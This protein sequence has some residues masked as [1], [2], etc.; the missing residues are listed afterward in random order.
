MNNALGLG[1][2]FDAKDLATGVMDRVSA[3]FIEVE[4]ASSRT[5]K[6]IQQNMRQFGLGLT[7]FGSGGAA[8]A[9]AT[10]L[11]NVSGLFSKELAAAGAVAGATAEE[12]RMFESAAL[13]AGMATS[14]DPTQAAR[15]LG[16]I[17][18]AGYS[19][20][21][22]VSTLIPVLQLAEGSLGKL[23]PSGAA[24]LATQTM[25]AFGIEAASAGPMVDKLLKSVN[26]FA[27][28]ADELPLAIGTAARGAGVMRQGLDETLVALGLVKN[29]I[30]RVETASTAVAVAMERMVNP[31]VAA[32]L[33]AQGVAVADAQGNFRPFLDVV[34]DLGGALE[35]MGTEQKRSGFL[36]ETFGTEALG[37][38]NA[39]MA[40]LTNGI[41]T[42][43]G[44]FVKGADAVAYLRD[45]FENST[46]AAKEFSDA[47]LDTFEGQKKLTSGSI[48][49]L[50]VLVGQPFERAL[51]PA[52]SGFLAVLN[53][54]IGAFRAMPESAKDFLA[55]AV[56][57]AGV[58]V[59]VLGGVLAAKAAFG[60]LAAGLSAAGVTAGGFVAAI[61]PAVGI[62]GVAAL[63]VYGLKAAV[64]ANIGGIGD[65]F[66]AAFAKARLA[67]DA[68]TQLFSQ[69]GFSGEVL[70]ELDKAENMGVENFVTRIWL[71]VNRVQEFFRAL[72]EAFDGAVT[73][74]GPVID[75][76]VSAFEELGRALGFMQETIDPSDAGAT[77]D[78]FGRAGAL[79][80]EV[81]GTAFAVVVE[82]LTAIVRV[83]TGVI[84]WIKYLG[85]VLAPVIDQLAPFGASLMMLFGVF[86]ATSSG[87][88]IE[89]VSNVLQVF[90]NVLQ[91]VGN[92]LLWA[93]EVAVPPLKFAID[94][95]SNAVRVVS[96]LLGGLIDFLA[97]VFT[98][99][100][101]RAF[102]GIAK[103]VGGVVHGIIVLVAGLV[104]ALL[105]LV[106]TVAAVFGRSLDTAGVVRGF[107]DDVGKN[108]ETTFAGRPP[109]APEAVVDR[110]IAAA[111][112][113][114]APEPIAPVSS[115]ALASQASTAAATSELTQAA[116]QLRSAKEGQTLVNATMVVDSEVLGRISSQAQR[117]STARGF[118]M[119]SVEEQ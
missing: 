54:I 85:G 88:W 45:G 17:A 53:G 19:A 62:L 9:G 109:A 41:R 34:Q 70:A 26:L 101:E 3:K 30:P 100:F 93:A 52:V 15:S 108:F 81:L 4:G 23:D 105:G 38:L 74:A 115:A 63:A 84:E 103:I 77:F 44:E 89:A 59:T 102:M 119:V 111:Q 94:M 16:D 21:D 51:K 98:L 64:D 71:T 96:L 43:S 118:G 116:T 99:N 36:V 46:G 42:S 39:I 60:I 110:D 55:R 56:L 47:L 112:A 95:V 86:G 57:V 117:S 7:L 113:F 58:L 5:A 83:G 1:F 12:L 104:E 31:E 66:T 72:G 29:I 13:D 49:T 35:K 68:L 18:Q 22:S 97:G 91:A 27:L 61:A 40:Q 2:V 73:R 11:A 92:V 90:G 107:L 76:L 65:T 10:A 79:A 33:K 78:A 75:G 69:G 6:A 8:L 106:D 82:V 25:K 14:F 50:A 80:G 32:A 37:G 20:A 114:L 24:G 67:W 28:S 87:R 48:S